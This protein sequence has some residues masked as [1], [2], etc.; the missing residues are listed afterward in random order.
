MQPKPGLY[1]YV[2]QG[3]TGLSEHSLP[4][5]INVIT[6]QLPSSLGYFCKG[7]DCGATWDCRQHSGALAVP[8]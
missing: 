3:L 7:P 2:V 4:Q 1:S 6:L 8:G 5:L